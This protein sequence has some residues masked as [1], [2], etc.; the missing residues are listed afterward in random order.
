MPKSKAYKYESFVNTRYK[1][2]ATDVLLQF[3]VFPSKGF[4]LKEAASMVAGESSVGTWT[5]VQT[6]NEKIGKTLSP[7]VY[8]INKRK[9]RVRIAYPIELFELGSVPNILSS[10]GGNVYGMKS[11]EGLFWED[12][13]FPEKMLKSFKGPRFGIPG[14]RKRLNVYNRPLIGTIVKPKVGLTP[15]EHAKVA[16]ESWLGGC[17][18]VK[19]DENL[20]S[21]IFNNFYKR[22]ELTLKAM[23]KAEKETGEKKV[24]LAN[25]T[26]ETE[27]MKKRIK[28]VEDKGGNYIM[29]DILTLGWAAVQTARNFTKLPIHAHRAG[30]AMYDR[31]EDSEGK[32]FGMSMEVIAQF[33]RMVGVDTLHIGTAYGKMSGAKDEVLHI[34]EEMERKFTKRT[35]EYL[36]QKWY[37]V[38]PVFGVASGGVYPSLVPKI[39]QFMGRDVVIQAGGGVHG[40]KFGTEAGARAMRQAV[41]AV[42]KKK[43]LKE[44]AK[45]HVELEEALRQWGR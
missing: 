10:V 44:Y 45:T 14:L 11:V 28:F 35:H 38:K 39:M 12:V 13:R 32:G 27:E 25:C 3:R 34:E 33:S 1:P 4:D 8:H 7:K 26:A 41:D 15:E 2:K 9:N 20:G 21:Q 5:D 36:S 19:D 23:R 22:V 42:L 40:H 17:D 37:E 18:I 24:Y 16:Y 29:L 6:M 31:I 43:S 30:H